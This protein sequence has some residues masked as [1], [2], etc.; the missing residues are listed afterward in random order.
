MCGART[1]A[2]PGVAG[3]AGGAGGGATLAQALS[4]SARAA[5]RKEDFM[6]ERTWP[7]PGLLQRPRG[8]DRGSARTAHARR[9]SGYAGR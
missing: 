3:A 7:R 4:S 1:P 8:A 5:A 2:A 9:R 6:R